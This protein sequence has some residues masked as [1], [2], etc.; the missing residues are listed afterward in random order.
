MNKKERGKREGENGGRR[1]ESKKEK[2]RNEQVSREGRS[3]YKHNRGGKEG[4]MTEAS[5]EG[6]K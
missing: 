5:K 2:K 3:K 6:S 4:N 1:E